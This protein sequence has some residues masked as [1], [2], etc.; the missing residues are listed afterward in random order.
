[1]DRDR[2]GV[3]AGE[4]VVRARETEAALP[5]PDQANDVDRL[6]QRVE[7]VAR[8]AA[9]PAVR[10]DGI[11]EAACTECQLEPAAAEH[12]EARGRFG[13]H[14]WWPQ[15]EVGDVRERPTRLVTAAI[16]PSSAQVSTKRRWYG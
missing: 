12:V 3:C 5:A 10:L 4:A 13:H 11:P 2:P 6:L 14:R 9:R 8:L 1:M 7:R 16:A 15:R